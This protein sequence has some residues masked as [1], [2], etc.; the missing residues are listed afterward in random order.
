[1]RKPRTGKGGR[2][3]AAEVNRRRRE[4]Q[5]NRGNNRSNRIYGQPIVIDGVPYYAPAGIPT[6]PKIPDGADESKY[7]AR[8][9]QGRDLYVKEPGDFRLTILMPLP[10]VVVRDK[11]SIQKA[12]DT[13]VLDVPE[14]MRSK[15]TYLDYHCT[16]DP[17][18]GIDLENWAPSKKWHTGDG[19][20]SELTQGPFRV[21]IHRDGSTFTIV[22]PDYHPEIGGADPGQYP[23]ELICDTYIDAQRTAEI[24]L[25][26]T[27]SCTFCAEAQYQGTNRVRRDD[28]RV[29][30]A[31]ADAL[32]PLFLLTWVY[33][34]SPTGGSET[35]RFA[36]NVDDINGQPD[37]DDHAIRS[38]FH[39][40]SSPVQQ[41]SRS[42]K[43]Q[44][45][46]EYQKHLYRVSTTCTHC[47]G[48]HGERKGSNAHR[49]EVIGLY[50]PEVGP[51][52]EDIQAYRDMVKQGCDEESLR[53][54]AEGLG[55]AMISH[56]LVDRAEFSTL[57]FDEDG[58]PRWEQAGIWQLMTAI[59][60]CP[61]T[62]QD[63]ILKPIYQCSTCEEPT[64]MQPSEC[65]T[66]VTLNPGKYFEF[67]M[68]ADPDSRRIF[69]P[70]FDALPLLSPTGPDAPSVEQLVRP[71]I[72]HALEDR[73]EEYLDVACG[74][75]YPVLSPEDQARLIG[76]KCYNFEDRHA[77]P[78]SGAKSPAAGKAKSKSK[79][80]G[81]LAF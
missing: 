1:M 23:E 57:V 69:W 45:W 52:P 27:H 64:P 72:D 5:Q 35:G 65:V 59:T 4:K 38:G 20:V 15:P 21:E 25:G 18:G 13:S 61:F 76:A 16:F 24:L 71:A 10:S 70:D 43:W 56:D 36:Y 29:W 55:I 3:A 33:G 54:T 31:Q 30:N 22:P 50:S 42:S 48:D 7:P 8:V 63:V 78:R 41:S 17:S 67:S 80:T 75:N 2:N 66:R 58:E 40:I 49:L 11:H 37:D 39:W 19:N 6:L 60:V 51:S 28:Q 77:A 74:G 81:G 73:F 53:A 46:E 32:I 44:T 34:Q 62:G 26:Q 47:L 79:K 12:V 9:L 68:F 14:Y